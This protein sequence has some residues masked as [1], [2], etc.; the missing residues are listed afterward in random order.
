[1]NPPGNALVG[2]RDIHLP[3]P[4]AFWPPAPG[5]WLLL[6]GLALVAAA[7]ALLLRAR[8]RS[9]RRA[10]LAE[11]DDLRARQREAVDASALAAALAGLLRR[12]ALARFGARRVA[13]LHGDAWCR[14]LCE[15]G[16]ARGFT[17]AL[18]GSLLHALYRPPH[19]GSHRDTAAWLE[20]SGHWI[21]ENT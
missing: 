17:P 19:P 16:G 10:A 14:F 3:E 13:S 5:W 15:H 12:V 11:L 1:M 18:A 6:V 9:V 4:V 20:A 7:A 8:R 2:L 21:R